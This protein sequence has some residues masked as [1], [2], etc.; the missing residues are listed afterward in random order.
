MD[1]IERNELKQVIKAEFD[2]IIKEDMFAVLQKY[3]IPSDQSKRIT[4][5]LCVWSNMVIDSDLN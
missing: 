3:N 4:K 5:D 1:T 2:I